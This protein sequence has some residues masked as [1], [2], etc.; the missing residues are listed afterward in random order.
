[1]ALSRAVWKSPRKDKLMWPS[2]QQPLYS[3]KLLAA[4]AYMPLSLIN[5]FNHFSNNWSKFRSL[6]ISPLKY[7]R[8]LLIVI[9]AVLHATQ[10]H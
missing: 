3:F 8:L 7:S 1:M 9:H 10:Y 2:P 5:Q 4:K 6:E